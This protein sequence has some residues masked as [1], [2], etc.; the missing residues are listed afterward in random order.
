MKH[1]VRNENPL[2]NPYSEALCSRPRLLVGNP[3]SLSTSSFTPF[4]RSSRVTRKNFTKK[5]KQNSLGCPKISPRNPKN[6][7]EKSKKNHQEIQKNY[8]EIH[9]NK[10]L[11]ECWPPCPTSCRPF[12]VI[13]N[14]RS[15]EFTR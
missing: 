3:C 10:K 4:G 5:S 6:F 14:S 12:M 8:Q 13:P 7:P 1:M 11:K 2:L 9:V 15:V